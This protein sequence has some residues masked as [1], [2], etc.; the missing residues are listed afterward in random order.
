M[1]VLLGLD[2]GLLTYSCT[3][4]VFTLDLYYSCQVSYLHSASPTV[5]TLLY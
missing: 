4:P 3:T 2:L 5:T 1:A